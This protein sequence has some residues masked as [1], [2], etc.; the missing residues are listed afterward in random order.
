MPPVFIP[1][2]LEPILVMAA[3]RQAFDPAE[4]WFFLF[5]RLVSIVLIARALYFWFCFTGLMPV[6]LPA[7][8]LDI[9]SP[10]QFAFVAGSAI[11][12]L[13]AAL[14]LWLLAPWGAVLW[15]VLVVCDAVFFFVVPELASVRPF[16]VLLNAGLV[17]IYLGL[18]LMVRRRAAARE[19]I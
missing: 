3:T 1:Q 9:G 4:V 7:Y 10:A 8:A 16:I 11:G 5:L 2:P 14:G 12:G 17:S 15:L 19:R 13:I 6:Y 18:A